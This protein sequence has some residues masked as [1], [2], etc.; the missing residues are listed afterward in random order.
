MDRQDMTDQRASAD[1]IEPTDSTEP[2]E[3][4]EAAEPI[5]PTDSTEPTD[6][7]ERIE[8]VDP[9]DRIDLSEPMD[10]S[11]SRFLGITAIM[12]DPRDPRGGADG[13]RP[14]HPAAGQGPSGVS[15]SA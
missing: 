15:P 4:A 2:I 3:K 9:M 7:I 6:P 14:P 8:L 12:L 10:H 1:R 5:E 11:E 13:T